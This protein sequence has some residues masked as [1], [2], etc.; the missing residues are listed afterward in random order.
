MKSTA[1]KLFW[2]AIWLAFLGLN[3][4]QEWDRFILAHP[5]A[6]RWDFVLSL[7][8]YFQEMFI[9]LAAVGVII[10][11]AWIVGARINKWFAPADNPPP[12]T[13]AGPIY[14][15][16]TYPAH[17]TVCVGLVCASVVMFFYWPGGAMVTVGAAIGA[18]VLL[19]RRMGFEP[20]NDPAAPQN[21]MRS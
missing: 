1:G 18:W 19:G 10:G 15:L 2:A 8:P 5:G 7:A 20:G 12:P 3:L 13:D 17:V 14:A 21:Q 9:S 4:S 11:L 6:S 16:R